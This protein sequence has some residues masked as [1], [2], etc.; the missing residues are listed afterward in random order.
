MVWIQW[1]IGHL[2]DADLVSFLRRCKASLKPGGVICIKDNSYSGSVRADL[3]FEHFCVDREDSSITRSSA[4]FEAVFAIAGLSVILKETQK[5][6][7][8]ELF[9]VLMYCLA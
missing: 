7:P 2:T 1:V 8:K 3:S 9:P 5:G 6:F 4:Y